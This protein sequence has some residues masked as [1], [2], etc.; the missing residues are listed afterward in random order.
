[1][2]TNIGQPSEFDPQTESIVAYI[3]RMQLFF[4]ANDIKAPKQVPVLLSLIGSKNYSLLRDL[5]SPILPQEAT[6]DEVAKVLEEHFEPQPSVIAERF[7]CHNCK[8]QSSQSVAD[9][10]SRTEKVGQHVQV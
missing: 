9:F 5:M 4:R 1:M 10:C 3:E 6:F 2:T 7:K 8:Q